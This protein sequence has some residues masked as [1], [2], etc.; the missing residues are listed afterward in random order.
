[1]IILL[2]LLLSNANLFISELRKDYDI[3]KE[4]H[5]AIIYM[6]M[7]DCVKCYLEPLEMSDYLNSQGVEVIAAVNCER[8]LE[9]NIFKKEKKWK[10]DLKVDENREIRKIMGGDSEIYMT[11]IKNNGEVKH[12]T[13]SREYNTF[14]ENKKRVDIFLK[15]NINV[16]NQF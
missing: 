3:P 2:M 13:K 8:K 7:I 15:S 11:I 16:K 12:F 5:I 9:L 1:M 10:Y 6:E 4:K 14:N